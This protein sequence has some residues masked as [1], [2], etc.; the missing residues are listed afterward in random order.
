MTVVNDH[1]RRHKRIYAN[2]LY[3]FGFKGHLLTNQ[4]GVIV[5]F[6]TTPANE[7][8]QATHI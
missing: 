7:D 1:A 5:D 2:F 6:K 3:F 8:R 4:D